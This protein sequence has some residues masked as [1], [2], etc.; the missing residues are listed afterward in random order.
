M[1]VSAGIAAVTCAIT[2]GLAGG[3]LHAITGPDHLAA[4]IPKCC[5]KRWFTAVRVGAVWGIG[6]GISSL[7]LGIS[8]YA[9]K[10]HLNNIHKIR[11]LLSGASHLLEVAVGLSL[12][13]VGVMGIR[14]AR[15]WE[16]DNNALSPI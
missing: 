14:E 2:G 13:L 16:E 9:L 10:N 1:G 7:I 15:E 12:L 11:T 8:A 4:L 3:S 6:H 5:G